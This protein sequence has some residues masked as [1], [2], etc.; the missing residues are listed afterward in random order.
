MKYFFRGQRVKCPP[1]PHSELTPQ[2]EN[3]FQAISRHQR[4]NIIF[5]GLAGCLN[6]ES[7]AFLVQIPLTPS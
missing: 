1:A 4:Q 7:F 6:S 3:P 5:P 2:S